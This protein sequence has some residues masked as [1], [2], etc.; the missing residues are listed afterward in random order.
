MKSTDGGGIHDED[1]GIVRALRSLTPD[2]PPA[3]LAASITAALPDL[4]A[5]RRSPWTRIQAWLERPAV[6]WSY[7]AAALLLLLGIFTGIWSL[8]ALRRMG[9]TS[10]A[11]GPAASHL[12]ALSKAPAPHAATVTF[13]FYAPKATSVSLVGTFNDWN[14]ALTPMTRGKDGTWS[15]QVSLASGRYEYMYFVDGSHFETDPNALELE[16]DGMGNENAV[17]RL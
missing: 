7:R 11:S 3:G 16:Q 17:L 5:P 14:P 1:E 12:A 13:V 9:G 15:V 4:P 10:R 2:R 8:V 6:I